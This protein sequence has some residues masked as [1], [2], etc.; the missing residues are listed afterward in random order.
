MLPLLVFDKPLFFHTLVTNK[1]AYLMIDFWFLHFLQVKDDTKR[2]VYCALIKLLQ[3]KNLSVRVCSMGPFFFSTSPLLVFL[4]NSDIFLPPKSI[5]LYPVQLLN[6]CILFQSWQPVGL[7]AYMLKMRTFQN[8]NL[9]I[10]YQYVG[11][12]ALSWLKKFRSL[13]PR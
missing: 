11:L 3:E 7:C 12:R 13:T 6:F 1:E 10:S 4:Y 9:L 2:Q 8:K 5:L